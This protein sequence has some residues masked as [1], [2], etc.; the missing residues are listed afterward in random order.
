MGLGRVV[1]RTTGARCVSFAAGMA[2]GDS[3]A[4][5]ADADG[6]NGLDGAVSMDAMADGIVPAEPS[7]ASRPW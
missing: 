2:R 7:F 5:G 3:D 6:S 1:V 4:D